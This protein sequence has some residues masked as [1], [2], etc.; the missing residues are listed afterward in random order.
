[1]KDT[2]NFGLIGCGAVSKLHIAAINKLESARFVAASDVSPTNLQQVVDTYHVRGYID[3]H[4]LL[5]DKSVDVVSILTASGLHASI[6]IEAAQYGK[7]VIVEKPIDVTIE[8]AQELIDACHKHKVF[9]S[10]IYQHRYDKPVIALKQA[11]D[12]GKLGRLNACCCHTKWYRTQEYF[13]VAKWRGTIALDGGALMNQSIHYID[14]MQHIMGP[15][16]E[17]FG[18][19]ATLA[20]Q[21]IETEDIG[22]AVLKFK[23]GALGIIEGSISAYPSFYTRLDVHGDKG[24][25]MLENDAILQWKT[26]DETDCAQELKI[27]GEQAHRLQLQEI[28]DAI[29]LGHQPLVTGEEALKALRIIL[30]IY[31]SAKTGI[32]VKL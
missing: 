12:Q 14:L 21:R 19:T 8:K 23:S 9:L 27:K 31:D 1:M 4:D 6:G 16:D 2:I 10:C 11:V 22:M 18:Y 30:A 26:Q 7:H 25:I 17:V 29:H 32:P 28:V 20:H 24:G 13:D 5:R 3:Y 15:V